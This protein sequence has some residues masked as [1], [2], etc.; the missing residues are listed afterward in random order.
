MSHSRAQRGLLP[1]EGIEARQVPE[2]GFPKPSTQ[3]LGM[4]QFMTRFRLRHF[5]LAFMAEAVH[6]RII[7]DP[8][9]GTYQINQ[10]MFVSVPIYMDVKPPVSFL[11]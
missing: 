6:C 7:R 11:L 5:S 4:R 8:R 3:M 10:A 9:S 1:R 2:L